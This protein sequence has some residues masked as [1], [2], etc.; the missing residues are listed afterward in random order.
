M[1]ENV[2]KKKALEAAMS[3]IEKQFGK[4]S[5][6][7]LGEFKA[8]EIEAIPT[9]ALSLDMALGIGG[10]PRGRIIEVFGPES[11]GK[12]T[13][14]LHVIAEAQKMGGEAAFIDAEHALDPVYAKKLGVDIDNLIVSQPDTGEQ[15]LEITESL[16]RSGALDV[17]VVDSVAALVP[18]AEIDGEWQD[19]YKMF[20]QY[21]K[22]VDGKLQNVEVEKY[23]TENLEYIAGDNKQDGYPQIFLSEK[24]ANQKDLLEQIQNMDEKGILDLNDWENAR[25]ATIAKELGVNP[26]NIQSMDEIDLEQL[27]NE[28]YSEIADSKENAEE[29]LEKGASKGQDKGKKEQKDERTTLS[30]KQMNGLNVKEETSLSQEIK[31]VT[32][33]EKLGLQKNGIS[34]A[35]KLARIS[36]SGSRKDAFVVIHSDGSAT[37]LGEDIL[38][39]DNRIG[40]SQTSKGMTINND[41]KVNQE[42]VTSSYRIVNGNGNE[43][44]RASYDESYGKEIKYSMFSPEKNQYLDV[45]LE[46]QRTRPQDSAVRQFIKDRGAGVREAEN[47]IERGE[48]HQIYGEMEENSEHQLNVKDVDNNKNNDTH[49]HLE[50]MDKNGELKVE[51][52]DYIPNTD[53]TWDRFASMCGYRGEDRLEKAVQRLQE[54]KEKDF[55]ASNQEL[56]EEIEEEENEQYRGN[57]RQR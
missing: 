53:I 48:E 34:D 11:S 49:E 22:E 55:D 23:V 16:V 1:A 27:I 12:T 44:I 42:G 36:I 9:G 3:Q 15:A 26:E 52:D 29:V 31:G 6:M 41:G 30:E 20:E 28:K 43:Y 10:V 24:Y 8:M 2:E 57:E 35:K 5:V 45:E 21:Q 19:I 40:T 37:V 47:V 13:L 54:E 32:L 33:G 56:I 7:K 50:Q 4:G 38:E 17:V 25:V 51:L 39:P 18:K 14:A 46:T